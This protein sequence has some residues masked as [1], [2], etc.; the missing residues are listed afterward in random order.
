MLVTVAP[1]NPQWPQLFEEEAK[2]LR[3]LLGENLVALFHIG[4]T[5]VP[6]LAAK[7]I[8]DILPVVQD[9]DA[10]DA[11]TPQFAELGYEAMGEFGLP[12][13]RY[14]RK[15]GE[16]RTHQIHAFQYDNL[17][18]IG[19]HLAFR[20]YLRAHPGARDSYAALKIQLASQFPADIDG[21]CDG[22]DAFVKEMERSALLWQ[23][24]RLAS[25]P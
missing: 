24:K 22:K 15:G 20:D 5:S 17:G 1:Y 11:L 7:P 21:Y 12:G 4:S 9:I 2:S 13:R 8:I 23:W 14:F 19:R 3:A 6:G 16:N 25:H 18:E 10:L